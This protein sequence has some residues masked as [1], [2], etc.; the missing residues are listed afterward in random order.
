M[1]KNSMI[2][3]YAIPAV[4][5]ALLSYHI[6]GAINQLKPT[7]TSSTVKSNEHDL[8]AAEAVCHDYRLL[9]PHLG[10]DIDIVTATTYNPAYVRIDDETSLLQWSG[11]NRETDEPA[12]FICQLRLKG[13]KLT[14]S[15]LVIDGDEVFNGQE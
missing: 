15:R 7:Q 10:K 6:F 4:L 1:K 3:V 13:D 8:H 14:L 2:L 12:L 5:V 11:R 9:Q